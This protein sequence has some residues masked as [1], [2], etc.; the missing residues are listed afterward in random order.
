LVIVILV[1]AAWRLLS[2]A[3]DYDRIS[4]SVD[5]PSSYNPFEAAK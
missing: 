1:L 3:K 2:G 4:K 5:I